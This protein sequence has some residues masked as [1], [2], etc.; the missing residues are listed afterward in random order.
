MLC[1]L[2]SV[3]FFIIWKCPKAAEV[4]RLFRGRQ[5]PCNTVH[6][7]TFNA[8]R[9]FKFSFYLL[10]HTSSQLR[11]MPVRAVV[12]ILFQKSLDSMTIR[13]ENCPGGQ[14]GSA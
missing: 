12:L 6:G 7:S 9:K 11:R 1:C 2:N 3:S 14:F 13:E 8:P 5:G 10:S 4:S